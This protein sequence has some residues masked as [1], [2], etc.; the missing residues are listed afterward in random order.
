[1]A[2]TTEWDRQAL[3]AWGDTIEAMMKLHAPMARN[4]ALVA[5]C[6]LFPSLM[7][8]QRHHLEAS[9]SGAKLPSA[10]DTKRQRALYREMVSRPVKR[11]GQPS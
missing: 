7:E 11:R 8:W 5:A 6:C 1:M 10:K 2:E 9:T 4:E 3:A